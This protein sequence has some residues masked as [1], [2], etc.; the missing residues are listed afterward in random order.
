[1]APGSAPGAISEPTRSRGPEFDPASVTSM[2]AWEAQLRAGEGEWRGLDAS[3]QI[4]APTPKTR[5]P[6]RL[7]SGLQPVLQRGQCSVFTSSTTPTTLTDPVIQAHRCALS[8][9]HFDMHLAALSELGTV[10]RM[11]ERP[12][13]THIPVGESERRK[14]GWSAPPHCLERWE[15]L[16]S[17]VDRA[18]RGSRSPQAPLQSLCSQVPQRV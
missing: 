10:S 13:V 7:A 11:Q 5:A 9:H 3:R 17:R 1:M 16:L 18:L 2:A 8:A 14:G 4:G 15:S 6:T 12:G